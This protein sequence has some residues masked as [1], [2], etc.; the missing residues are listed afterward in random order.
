MITPLGSVCAEPANEANSPSG[1]PELCM[2][3]GSSLEVFPPPAS[4]STIV[5]KVR[6]VVWNCRKLP[7]MGS[8]RSIRA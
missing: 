6:A 1:K 3:L 4:V 8:T 7:L 2:H 5:E